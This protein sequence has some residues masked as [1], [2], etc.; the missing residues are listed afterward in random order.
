VPPLR[1]RREDV[2]ALLDHFLARARLRNRASVARRFAP[3]AL[4]RLSAHG[5]PGNVRE[6]ENLVE[7]LVLLGQREEIGLAEL[8]E[9]AVRIV[10]SPSPIA[11]A[12]EKMVTLRELEAQYIAWVV[13][14]CGGNKTRAA[15]V[16]GID[17]S[18]IY[19]RAQRE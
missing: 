18:T 13:E 3:E 11:Q 6:L 5:W 1:D 16:L 4:E 8:E 7:R 14:R 17:A 10:A 15:E 12:Q 2:P 19:R 9:F